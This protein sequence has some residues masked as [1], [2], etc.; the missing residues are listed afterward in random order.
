MDEF[1]LILREIGNSARQHGVAGRILVGLS[2]GADSVALLRGLCALRQEMGFTLFAVYVNHGLRQAAE[3]EEVFCAELCRGLDVPLLIKRVQVS[4]S[5]SR[6]AA[7]RD[8][9]YRAFHEAMEEVRTDILALAHHSNDQAETLLLHL[10]YGTGSDGLSGMREYHPPVWRPLLSLSRDTLRAALRTL[11]QDWREDESNRDTALTRNAIRAELLPIMERLFP[12]T[13]PALCRAAEILG[14]ENDYLREQAERWLSENAACGAWH[15]LLLSPLRALHP[16]MQRRV[17]RGYAA[18]L[19]MNLEFGHTEALLAL[20]ALPPGSR[21]N[22]PD[23]WHALR[24]K[25]RLHFL[26]PN[27]Q[28]PAVQRDA[29]HAKPFAGSQGDGLLRQTIPADLWKSATL[30]TRLPGDRITPFGM[31]GSMKLKDYLISKGVDQPFRDGWPLLCQ[32][33]EVLWVIGVGAS[34]LLRFRPSAAENTL[35]LHYAG[36]L[37]DQL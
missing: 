2:G 6:E 11:G 33:Q 31:Q 22:L 24:T 23:G 29:L 19:G 16:A 10:M 37:P 14:S 13:V 4:A 26:P 3:E 5:G 34:E 28:I 35:M 1:S 20:L 30:R 27:A 18:N 21:E 12:Q 15:F 9:R 36:R 25:E 8:A 17:V 32:G 7:A